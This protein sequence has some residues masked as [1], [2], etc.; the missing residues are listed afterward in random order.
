MKEAIF[1]RYDEEIGKVICTACSRFCKLDENKIG[2]CGVRM[3]K[4]KKLYL[5][6][7]GI[8]SSY[9]LDPIEKKPFF[10]FFPGSSALS[11]GT[12]GCNFACMFCCNFDISQRRRVEGKEIPVE[13]I[14]EKAKELKEKFNVSSVTFTYNE[15]TIY[16]EFII[17]A[18]KVLRKDFKI[19]LV[20][21]G[22]FSLDVID[23][24]KKFVDAVVVDIKGNG[25][26]NFARKFMGVNYYRDI[27]FDSIREI[28]K[29]VHL[30]I[31]DLVVPKYG[32]SLEDCKKLCRFLYDLMGEEACIH[33]LR[34][35]PSYKITE[36]PETDVKILEEHIKIAKSEGIKFVYIGNVWGHENENT[37]CP[38]CGKKVIERF[39]FSVT[40]V[41]LIENRCKFCGYKLPIVGDANISKLSYP[42][43]IEF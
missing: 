37:F 10:H 11:F 39:G 18:S 21:N 33:F 36:I 4:N 31:T 3:A 5:L 40:N 43:F 32:D 12:T 42:M 41:N 9:A 8:F 28:Y 23:Y 1:Y 27:I 22:Y 24:I 29:K 38:S 2:F 14:Y 35:F 30:E 20:S 6:N 25:N 26:E 19:T 13:K 7:Y 34:F 17:D 16:F 15:P